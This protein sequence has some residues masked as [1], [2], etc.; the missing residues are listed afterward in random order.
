MGYNLSHFCGLYSD[1]F[2]CDLESCS[3]VYANGNCCP[4]VFSDEEQKK[5]MEEREA[6]PAKK[7]NKYNM[8]I[9]LKGVHTAT[10][11]PLHD[12][13]EDYLYDKNLWK[14]VMAFM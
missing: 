2:N 8:G 11:G 14:N 13:R 7:Y 5:F 10:E 12:M 1:D 4:L 6:R 9:F 3:H